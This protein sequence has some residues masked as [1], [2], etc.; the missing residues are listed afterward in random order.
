[1]LLTAGEVDL[2]DVT[3]DDRL[4]AEADAGQEHLHLL[5]RRVLCLVENDERVIE[6]PAAHVGERRDLD[7]IALEK[8]RGLVEAHKIVQRVVERTQIGVDLLR[9]IAGKK[10]QPLA[11]LDGGAHQH[12]ALDD[13][14]FQR[15]DRAGDGEIRL[16]GAGRSDA[17]SDVVVLDVL[18]IRDLVRRSAVQVGA[19][20]A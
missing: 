17:E 9:E 13:V 6:R 19:A 1:M 10:T 14:A 2:C 11:G 7:G 12:E 18:Q 3:G 5:G 20:S 4:G 15:V 16:A 8:L